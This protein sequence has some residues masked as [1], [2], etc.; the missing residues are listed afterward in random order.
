MRAGKCKL[1]T[2]DC[3]YTVMAQRG[4]LTPV[5]LGFEFYSY[6]LKYAD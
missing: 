4:V 6:D 1:E 5:R 2:R 3:L